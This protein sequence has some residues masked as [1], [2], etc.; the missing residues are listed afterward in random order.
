MVNHYHPGN[1]TYMELHNTNPSF[2]K[3]ES[4]RHGLENRDWG[5]VTTHFNEEVVERSADW[6]SSLYISSRH[7]F[8]FS[9]IP[10]C[11]FAFSQG[12]KMN[13]KNVKDTAL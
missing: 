2:A 5:Y 11:I 13:K 6:I 9:G 1:A 4:L 8:F 7:I 3:V 10:G 12:E